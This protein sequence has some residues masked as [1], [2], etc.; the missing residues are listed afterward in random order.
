MTITAVVA[1][2]APA[3]S[4]LVQFLLLLSLVIAAAKLAGVA[5]T[6]LGQPA[7]FGEL[8]VGLLLG[9]TVLDVMS[10]PPSLACRWSRRA[11]TTM[12][13][14][15]LLRLVYP[16]VRGGTHVAVEESFTSIPP[17]VHDAI[18]RGERAAARD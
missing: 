16:K 5:A 7:V 3:M 12:I 15:P 8:L 14:P 2:S 17:D 9:P 10:W 6:R 13:T 1:S 4:H 18:D 11:V